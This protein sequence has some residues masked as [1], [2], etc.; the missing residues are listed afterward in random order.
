LIPPSPSKLEQE[1]RVSSCA[2]FE[3]LPKKERKGIVR[4]LQNGKEFEYKLNNSPPNSRAYWSDG[5]SDGETSDGEYL[6]IILNN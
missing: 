6:H 2:A 3:W 1:T 4:R 5:I